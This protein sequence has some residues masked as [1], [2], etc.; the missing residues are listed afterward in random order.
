MTSTLTTQE[1]IY[2]LLR[3]TNHAGA[4]QA[5]AAEIDALTA[6]RDEC[7][8]S[9]A[10]SQQQLAEARATI[11]A[12]N[13][14]SEAW[15]AEAEAQLAEARAEVERLRPAAEAWRTL[16]AFRSAENFGTLDDE[17][18]TRKIHA[19]ARD[20]ARAAKGGA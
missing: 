20:A 9:W 4:S 13:A 7:A 10:M 8:R 1:R 12:N 11:A 6:E 19:D 18:A 15:E 16:E 2:D 14:K 17:R 3:G 5:I